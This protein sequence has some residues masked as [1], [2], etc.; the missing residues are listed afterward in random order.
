MT[1]P[2]DVQ[3]LA[4]LDADLAAGVPVDPAVLADPASRAVLDALAATR[5]ELASLPPVPVPP[6]I[7]A[8]WTAALAAEPL[9]DHQF[10]APAAT[11]GREHPEPVIT[12]HDAAPT[13]G[14]GSRPGGRRGTGPPSAS[15][16][17]RPAARA[18]RT[19]PALAVGLAL[20]ALLVVTG[21]VRARTAPP[22]ITAAELGGFAQAAVG[23]HDAGELADP[24]RRAGCLR[25]VAPPELNPD[26]PLIGGR[27]VDIDGR[28]GVLLVLATGR[29]GTFRV[30]V[31][32]P[33]CGPDGGTL[34]ADT[35]IGR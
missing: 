13:A 35:L 21:V 19:R 31:V 14:P 24:A 7:A 22:G 1:E 6:E 27:G 30:V 11:S 8:R 23:A 10:G 4:R 3:R 25:S 12:A 9:H 32:D 17:S 18:R 26:A 28:H 34:L 33:A 15:G 20:V 16:P 2:S 29:L 5:A